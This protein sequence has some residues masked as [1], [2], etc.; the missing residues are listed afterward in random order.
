MSEE[1]PLVTVIIPA[2]N[3]ERELGDCLRRVLEQDYPSERMEVLIA[4]GRS[5]DGTRAL[6]EQAANAH[7]RVR[8]ID[9]PTGLIPQGLN[10]AI[11]Q[12]W[13]EVI[14]RVD[15]HARIAR[16]YLRQC[17]RILYETGAGNVGGPVRPVGEGYWGA[18][19]AAAY[20]SW[21][22]RGGGKLHDPSYRGEVDTV[23]LGCFPKPVLEEL[24]GFDE[25][26]SKNQDIEL[27]HRLIESGHKVFLDPEIRSEYVVRS[28]LRAL[29]RYHFDTGW[30]NIISW[31][32]HP[33][34]LSLRHFVPLAFVL[35][36]IALLVW[37]AFSTVGR[38]ALGGFG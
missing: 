6:A 20:G 18:A 12:A 24:G 17:V 13:G 21:F 26:L 33:G 37:A 32:R 16:D 34:S 15:A 19:I 3:A 29:W 28:S 30:W 11:A 22:G 8:L 7:S 9:N 27:N 38:Q 5:A 35:A 14:V 10:R 31:R 36:L 25:S 2:R 4:E 1:L 23:Y